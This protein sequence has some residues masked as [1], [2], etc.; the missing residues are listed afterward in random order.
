MAGAYAALIVFAA[1]LLIAPSVAVAAEP[2]QADPNVH[3]RGSLANSRLR[4]ERQK[5]GHVAFIGGSITEMDG[6]RPMVSALLQKRFPDTAFTFT[7][8]GIAST[9][10]TTGAFRVARDVLSQGPVD[11]L[12]VEFA[13]NDDQD[14]HHTRQE[15]IRGMEGL[16]RQVRR[17]NPQAD[18][19]ITYFVNP[20]ML[21]DLRAGKTPL[22]IAAHEAVAEHYGIS[23]IHLAREVAQR[24]EKGTLTWEKFGGVHPAPA[25]NAIAAE[26]IGELLTKAWSAPLSADPR[27]VAHP[28]PEP[29]DALSYANGRFIDPKEARIQQ[30]WQLG[31]PEWKKLKGGTRGRFTSIPMLWAQQSGAELTLEF[32]GTTVGAYVVA[33]PDAGM[34]EARVDDGPAQT[35]DLYHHFSAGLHYPRTV[36]LATDLPAGKHTLRLRVAEQTKSA[37]HA[38]RIMEFVGN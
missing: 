15:C 34:V 13:V 6:Y 26:M 29:L 2:P 31:V 37:G 22:P 7:N 23:T 25:G 9:C 21:A 27:K 24:I 35:V 10:S 3:L 30:G 11:L 1:A 19:V 12:F 33:G 20:E 28:T 5:Q 18:I 4:F 14:A 38:A 32:T 17:H 8:A 16:I 36:L